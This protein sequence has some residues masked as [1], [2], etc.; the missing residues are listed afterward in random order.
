MDASTN[1]MPVDFKDWEKV[2]RSGYP[3][4][5]YFAVYAVEGNQVLSAVRTIRLP[6]TMASGRQEIISG[7]VGV[8]TRREA[9]RRGLARKL[10]QEVHQREADV[11]SKLAVLQTGYGNVA[12]NLYLSMGYVDVFS[13]K[14]AMKRL[15]PGGSKRRSPGFEVRP[16]KL[17]D[18]ETIERLHFDATKGRVGFSPR[19]K[20]Y[21][22]AMFRLGLVEPNS[23]R[24]I[25]SERKPVG[26][27]HLRRGRG[28]FDLDEVVTSNEIDLKSTLSLLEAE[29]GQGWIILY[30]TFVNDSLVE[31]KRRGYLFNE[32][33]YS[34][35][36]A[37]PLGDKGSSNVRKEMGVDSGSF[38]CQF[39]DY[40]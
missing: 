19:P 29:A 5:D 1:W 25:L 32:H 24:L 9:S 23:Y 2:R 14:L 30:S 4:S 37:R 10:L 22:R 11:G 21:L 36:L 12:Y 13:V 38:T 35:F 39:L 18:T 31:L 34:G 17:T 8:V 28:W 3:A 40:F 15:G 6:Y 16:V 26:Y 33:T 20:G 27:F 7:I